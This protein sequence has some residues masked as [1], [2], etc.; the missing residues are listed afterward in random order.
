MTVMDVEIMCQELTEMCS[1]TTQV[2]AMIQMEMEYG[3]NESG[4]NPDVFPLDST[5]G[6]IMICS[7]G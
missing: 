3:D 4:V 1:Q 6:K 2:D 5:N 7:V